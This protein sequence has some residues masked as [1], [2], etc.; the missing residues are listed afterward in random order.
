MP[1]TRILKNTAVTD[2]LLYTGTAFDT[3]DTAGTAARG[4]ANASLQRPYL[5]KSNI[6]RPMYALK[7]MHNLAMG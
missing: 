6:A 7:V 1:K 2:W 5:M 3:R 4:W